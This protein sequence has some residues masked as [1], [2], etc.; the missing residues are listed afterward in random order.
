MLS[1][2][3][4]ALVSASVAQADPGADETCVG[5]KIV[6]SYA[7]GWQVRSQNRAAL[8]GGEHKIYQVT[9]YA[10]NEYKLLG[11]GEDTVANV[12]LVLYDAKGAVLLSDSTNDREPQFSYTPSLTGT[13]Y[14]AVHASR[15][16][17]GVARANISTA[18]LYK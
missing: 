17:E 9:L 8:G 11:C 2:V 16:N 13:F 5:N 18:V 6:D 3:A 10:G 15:L 14:L 12:D 4:L 1:F 7:S